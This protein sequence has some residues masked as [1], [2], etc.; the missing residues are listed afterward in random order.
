MTS[1]CAV[2]R[3]TFHQSTLGY[4]AWV[5]KI[6]FWLRFWRQKSA[7]FEFQRFWYILYVI[8]QENFGQDNFG[9]DFIGAKTGGKA[10]YLN[11]ILRKGGKMMKKYELFLNEIH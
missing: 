1:V 4:G 10:V 8:F 7:L 3:G 9:Q 6:G 11:E 5:L 2:R